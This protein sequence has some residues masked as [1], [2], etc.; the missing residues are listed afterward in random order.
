[1]TKPTNEKRILDEELEVFRA[2]LKRKLHSQIYRIFLKLK[3]TTGLTQKDIAERLNIDQALVSKRLRGDANIT[4]DTISDLARA[5]EATIELSATL[6]KEQTIAQDTT[7]TKKTEDTTWHHKDHNH[8]L[9]TGP[10]S[11]SIHIQP[12]EISLDEFQKTHSGIGKYNTDDLK[13]REYRNNTTTPNREW[14]SH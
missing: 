13:I 10:R 9:T 1:M 8:T 11:Q 4:L 5:M 7:T 2:A 14:S 6:W 3:K 12:F